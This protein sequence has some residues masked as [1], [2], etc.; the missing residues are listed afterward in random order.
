MIF[1]A[2]RL[3]SWLRRILKG[4]L[5]SGLGS[6][7]DCEVTEGQVVSPPLGCHSPSPQNQKEAS[8]LP[9]PSPC[10]PQ[11]QGE[12]SLPA[13]LFF[14]RRPATL[15]R[16]TETFS[17]GSWIS[18]SQALSR[19][20]HLL[21][22]YLQVT[23]CLVLTWPMRGKTCQASSLGFPKAWGVPQ[24]S[25]FESSCLASPT[26]LT[27][28]P[29]G[30]EMKVSG[31]RGVRKRAQGIVPSVSLFY[32]FLYDSTLADIFGLISNISLYGWFSISS[33]FAPVF[34]LSCFL[35][36]LMD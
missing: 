3:L 17:G 19:S 32:C 33:I 26:L 4:A 35:W 1:C 5:K 25:G 6:I 8:L 29:G 12:N 28:Q 23:K 20:L 27:W 18:A 13:G 21:A 10:S 2:L 7:S 11:A 16:L 9:S 36:E 15:T 31:S 30:L 24:S 22:L 34:L 14:S